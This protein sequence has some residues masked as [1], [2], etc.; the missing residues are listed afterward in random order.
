[1][2]SDDFRPFSGTLAVTG[3]IYSF[4]G[5][6]LLHGQTPDCIGPDAQG[7]PPRRPS[8]SESATATG[9]TCCSSSSGGS[10]G[11]RFSYSFHGKRKLLSMGT[12]PD[13]EPRARPQARR[14]RR[15]RSSPRDVD[16]SQ[17]RKDG[18]GCRSGRSGQRRSGRRRVCRLSIR[19]RPLARDWFEV[20]R[21]SWAPSYS[22]KIIERLERDVFPW[23]GKAPVANI[24][25]PLLLEVLRRI[26][27]R[28]VVETAHRALRELQPDLPLRHRHRPGNDQ[29]RARLEGWVASDLRRSTSRRS[30]S[31]SG[32]RELLRA[33]DGYAATHV[34]RAALEAVSRCSAPTRRVS[35]R[36]VERD[37]PRPGAMDGPCG[38]HEAAAASA[39]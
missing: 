6:G 25:P 9:S 39:S 22:Q 24:T 35:R 2:A 21:E 15:A 34:V 14:R 17:K 1:M 13:D 23:L 20:R 38:A 19:S 30:P 28:G 32:S 8:H 29:S 12:Y 10:H 36:G 4:G 26:E 27:A 16:P 11:W 18:Q 33:C 3:R 37:R 7:D 31:P 5:R